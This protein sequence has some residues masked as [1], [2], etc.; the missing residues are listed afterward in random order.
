MSMVIPIKCP[1]CNQM[2]KAKVLS[3]DEKNQMY[4]E[5]KCPYCGFKWKGMV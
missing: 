2:I 3:V 4:V 1:R 5:V